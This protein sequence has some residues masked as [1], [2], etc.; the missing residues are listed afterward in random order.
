MQD[1][2]R[3]LE[4][5]LDSTG[6]VL[7]CGEAGSGRDLF[8]K[9]IHLGSG[10]QEGSTEGLLRRSMRDEGNGRPFVVVDCGHREALDVRLFGLEPPPGE[11]G[12]SLERIHAGCV[13]HAG[14]GGT[15]VFR[16]LSEMP[17]R[18]Q[19]RL[20]RILRDGEVR[21][22]DE[23]GCERVQ[24][25]AVRPIATAGH[26]DGEDLVPE[27]QKRMA[28]TVIAVPS[29]RSRR[30]DI[31]GLVRAL[32]ADIC[33]A[34]G[35]PVKTASSQ[36]V[37]LL[38]ALPW[39]GNVGELEMLLRRLARKTSGRR[40]RLTHVLA[41]VRIDGHSGG[42]SYTGTLKQA[43]EQFERDYVKAVL[44]EH[45]GRMA[46]AAQA[47]GLQRTNLYRKVRQLSVRRGSFG[48]QLL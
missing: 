20:A 5:A 41:H 45:R 24:Q 32:L 28:Q 6:G 8:A 33:A 22:I 14:F 31:P 40:I 37:D 44:D 3:G 2:L 25:V 10:D 39:R 35:I 1:A 13:L 48:R 17:A 11:C 12:A 30:E 9:A 21:V 43:R 47:L 42:P 29:L 19:L 7:L 15:I 27:L 18:L 36:A 34:A 23:A 46:E 38:A 26:Q 4:A 16:Q